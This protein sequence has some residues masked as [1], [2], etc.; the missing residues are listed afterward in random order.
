MFERVS[1]PTVDGVTIVGTW[2]E[3]PAANGAVILLHMMPATRDSWKNVQEAFAKKGLSTLAIDLRGHGESTQGPNGSV[4][5]FHEFTDEMHQFSIVDIEAAVDWLR[6]KQYQLGRMAFMGGSIGATLAL[7]SLADESRIPAAVL[8]SPGDYRGFDLNQE[9]KQ[10]HPEQALC[11][12]V[13]AND[14]QA[15][16]VSKKLSE[17]APVEH[18]EFIEYADAGHGTAILDKVPELPDLLADWIL[19]SLR[20]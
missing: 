14:S 10:L 20:E 16:L 7:V 15:A 11:I 2:S 17:E 13:S 12:L 1:F 19:A 4:L 5:N 8:L 9:S 3:A 6:K 18:K